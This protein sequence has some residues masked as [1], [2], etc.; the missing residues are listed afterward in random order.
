MVFEKKSGLA[1]AAWALAVF[2]TTL[3]AATV[4][5]ADDARPRADDK[6]VARCDEQSDQCML[7]AG[8]DSQKQRAC[9]SGYD[10]CLRKC[11]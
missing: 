6:C 1:P 11:S 3:V 5:V 9:D 7:D 10:D 4:A 2:A 8:K